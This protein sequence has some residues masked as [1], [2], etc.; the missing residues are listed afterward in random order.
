MALSWCGVPT[1]WV[2]AEASDSDTSRDDCH[3]ISIIII[4]IISH[5]TRGRRSQFQSRRTAWHRHTSEYLH[6]STPAWMRT[7]LEAMLFL[8]SAVL[9]YPCCARLVALRPRSTPSLGT[10][11]ACHKH[12][13]A[14]VYAQNQHAHIYMHEFFKDRRL[15]PASLPLPLSV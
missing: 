9:V 5:N 8:T 13:H 7:H 10:S 1:H 12:I 2:M 3:V 4:I 14:W 11:G 6:L 15:A